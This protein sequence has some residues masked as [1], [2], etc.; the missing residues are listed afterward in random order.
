MAS[1]PRRRSVSRPPQRAAIAVT[2]SEGFEWVWELASVEVDVTPT[3][4]EQGFLGLVGCRRTA[5][6]TTEARPCEGVV[7]AHHL[8]RKLRT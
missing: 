4:G 6:R 7:L 8:Q 5:T 2:I 1:T 3:L